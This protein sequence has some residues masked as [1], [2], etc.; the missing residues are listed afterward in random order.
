MKV[1]GLTGGIASGKGVVAQML[2]KL[3]AAVIDADKIGHEILSPGKPAWQELVECF[4]ESILK[5][6][7]TIDR[8]RLADIVFADADARGKL[9][10]ITHPRIVEEIKARMVDLQLSGCPIAIIEAALIGESGGTMG[11]DG[12][13][14][15]YASPETQVGRLMKRDGVSE[16]EALDRIKAQMPASEKKKLADYLIDNSGSIEET[17]TQVE[18]LWRKLRGGL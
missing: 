16:E 6:D 13:I 18:T 2:E 8:K 9:N 7:R 17:R 14:V 12:I 4:G 11:L 3:G 15:V 10:S 5:P 1:F